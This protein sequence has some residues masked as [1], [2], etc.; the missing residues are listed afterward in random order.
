MRA[1]HA[2]AACTNPSL[3]VHIRPSSLCTSS[4]LL[5]CTIKATPIIARA[6]TIATVAA[7]FI[8]PIFVC[9]KW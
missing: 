7:D 1:D 2:C 4:I 5:Q 8:F 6:P 3:P 9:N